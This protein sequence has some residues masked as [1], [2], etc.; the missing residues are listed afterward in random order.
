MRIKRIETSK[1][2]QERVLVYPEEG[3]PLRITQAELLQFG[4]HTGMD[5]PPELVVE[6]QQRGRASAL[7]AK[8]AQLASGRMLSKKELK[9]RLV[10]KGAQQDEAEDIAVWLEDVGALDESGYAAVLVRHYAAGHYGRRRIEQEL[11]RRGIPRQL[12]DEA[13]SQLPPPQEA[14]AAY[15]AGKCRGVAPDEALCRRLSNA[16]LR[17]GFDWRDIRPALNALG[18]AIDE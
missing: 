5:I 7:R 14:I 9:D 1:Y 11:Q 8:G 6:L 10:R 4:L 17:R 2:V 18:S 16:L 12:W 15:L 13:L 3:D